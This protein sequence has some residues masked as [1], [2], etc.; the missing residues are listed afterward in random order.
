MQIGGLFPGLP[1]FEASTG[2]SLMQFIFLLGSLSSSTVT[3]GGQ[4][5][6]ELHHLNRT[7]YGQ[8][9]FATMQ[10]S[11]NEPFG[12]SPFRS[13]SPV[14]PYEPGIAEPYL[15]PREPLSPN[16]GCENADATASAK[17][18]G[19]L[20]RSIWKTIGRCTRCRIDSRRIET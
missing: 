16:T 9:F 8:L 10:V 20:S 19:S 4:R 13:V 17:N 12:P 7:A 11:S 5:V 14:E 3:F 1:P 15:S 6:F 2:A 18:R